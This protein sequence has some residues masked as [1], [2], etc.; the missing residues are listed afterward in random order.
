MGLRA[1][2]LVV[3]HTVVIPMF[4]VFNL[5]FSFVVIF[6]LVRAVWA[7]LLLLGFWLIFYNW[8][9]LVFLFVTT[10]GGTVV[11]AGVI[12]HLTAIFLSALWRLLTQSLH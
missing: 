11:F 3:L 7:I 4:W 1:H 10:E 2:L 8:L 12:S 5:F 9:R 6:L